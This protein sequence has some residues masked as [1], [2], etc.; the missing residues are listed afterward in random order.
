MYGG[1]GHA[2]CGVISFAIEALCVCNVGARSVQAGRNPE[3]SPDVGVLWARIVQA[4][5]N[6]EGCPE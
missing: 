4:G 3:G 6:L 1:T 2:V 5:E